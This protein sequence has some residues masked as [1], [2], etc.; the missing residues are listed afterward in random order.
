MTKVSLQSTSEFAFSH[1]QLSGLD[2]QVSVLGQDIN[3]ASAASMMQC[4]ALFRGTDSGAEHCASTQY[5]H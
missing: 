3:A 2:G 5:Q 1:Q 4:G